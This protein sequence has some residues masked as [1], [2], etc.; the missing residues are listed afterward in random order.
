MVQEHRQRPVRHRGHGALDKRPGPP[1]KP[2]PDDERPAHVHAVETSGL[3]ASSPCAPTESAPTSR[4]AMRRTRGL[5]DSAPTSS[6]PSGS[7]TSAIAANAHPAASASSTL[8]P[9]DGSA[10]PPSPSRATA[11]GEAEPDLGAPRHAH[12][13][14]RLGAG[15]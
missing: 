7:G 2:A 11:F 14:K 10:S 15:H 6:P 1:A 5:A 4:P 8:T 12:A 9:T 3:N 13:D